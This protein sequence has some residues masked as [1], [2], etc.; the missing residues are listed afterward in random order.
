MDKG[1]LFSTIKGRQYVDCKYHPT[2]RS[3]TVM[4]SYCGKQLA[5]KVIAYY[6]ATEIEEYHF[7]TYTLKQVFP[8]LLEAYYHE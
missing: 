8:D 1:A 7:N 5:M 3:Q 2:K 4:L 6:G